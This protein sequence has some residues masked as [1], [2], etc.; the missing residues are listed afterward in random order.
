MVLVVVVVVVKCSKHT[1]K[2]THL[3]TIHIKLNGNQS[4]CKLYFQVKDFVV[5]VVEFFFLPSIMAII[6]W[7]SSSSSSLAIWIRC[8]VQTV[9][10][11]CRFK[12]FFSLFNRKKMIIIVCWWQKYRDEMRIHQTHT[13]T[14]CSLY[15]VS[16]EWSNLIHSLILNFFSGS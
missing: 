4:N 13:H 16:S 2:H 11:L 12:V 5:V 9:T 6:I 10:C 14:K 15:I 3:F 7:S 8:F 1:H